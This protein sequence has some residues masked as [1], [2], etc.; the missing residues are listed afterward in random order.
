MAVVVLLIMGAV[1][2]SAERAAL[3]VALL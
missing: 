2:K 1:G 3:R